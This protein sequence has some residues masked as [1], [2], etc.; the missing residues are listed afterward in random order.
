[1]E[2]GFQCGFRRNQKLPRENH[3]SSKNIEQEQSRIRKP[4]NKQSVGL[5]RR[6]KAN[7]TQRFQNEMSSENVFHPPNFSETE[8]ESFSLSVI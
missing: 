2:I 8:I 7:R 5:D 4:F 6:G 1:M 3:L